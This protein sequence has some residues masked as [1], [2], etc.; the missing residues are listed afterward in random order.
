[1]ISYAL[2]GPESYIEFFFILTKK[3]FSQYLV[4]TV[5]VII[6]AC[7]TIFG[8]GFVGQFISTFTLIK[9]SMLFAMIAIAGVVG[10][11]INRNFTDNWVY[12]GKPFFNGNC[13]FRW[14]G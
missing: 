11:Q 7:F 5:F 1:M 13:C 14:C 8:Y 12:V 4:I 3:Y 6:L 9:G 10:I 2:A